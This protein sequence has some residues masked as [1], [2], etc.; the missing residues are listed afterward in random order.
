METDF[1]IQ[2]GHGVLYPL[3]NSLEKGG[4]LASK[5]EKHGGRTRKIYEITPKGI[6]LVDAYYEFLKEQTEMQ[7]TKESAEND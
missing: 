4:F 2:L 1:Q 5:K 3:L 7:N 6:Q